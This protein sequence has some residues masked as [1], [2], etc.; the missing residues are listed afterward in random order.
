MI[1]IVSILKIQK[2][3]KNYFYHNLFDDFFYF[4]RVV[5]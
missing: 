4:N 2:T 1:L 5:I 3:I